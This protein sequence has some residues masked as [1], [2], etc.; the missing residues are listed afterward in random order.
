MKAAGLKDMPALEAAFEGRVLQLASAAGRS[1]IIWQDVVDN[2][3]QVVFCHVQPGNALLRPC[4]LCEGLGKTMLQHC[5]FAICSLQPLLQ[6]AAGLLA[7]VPGESRQLIS[8]E[9]T[10]CSPHLGYEPSVA[11]PLAE[12]WQHLHSAVMPCTAAGA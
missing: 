2:G 4:M 3:V 5:E 7:S 8:G 12:A 1:Y 6:P 10:L 9:N 11:L